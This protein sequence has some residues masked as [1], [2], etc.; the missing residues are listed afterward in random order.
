MLAET[1]CD[2]LMVA[3]GALG[4]PWIFHQTCE[5]LGGKPITAASCA[6]RMAMAEQHLALFIDYAGASVAVREMKKH[7]GWYIHGVP[8]AAALRRTVNTAHDI[9]ELL[10]VIRQIKETGA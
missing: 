3:R 1:G 6:D 10:A 4:N 8:G 5:L 9:D 2:G 7:L